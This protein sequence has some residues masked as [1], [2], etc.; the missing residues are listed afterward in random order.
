VEEWRLERHF[1]TSSAC[2]VCGK[3]G[4]EQLALRGHRPAGPGPRL[5]AATIYGLP[6]TLR[7]AQG[8]FADTGGLHAAGLFSADGTLLALR[9]DV[10]RHNALD[11]LIGWALREGRLPLADQVV[12][13]S[14]RSSFEIVQKALAAGAPVV[15]AVSAPSSLAIAVAQAFDITLVGFMRGDRFNVYSGAGRVVAART[16]TPAPAGP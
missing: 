2:G 5:D 1:F 9:E 11:K 12:M 15:C 7:A 3:A 10:G 16:G 6:Q 14:G 8:V 4:I 13:V